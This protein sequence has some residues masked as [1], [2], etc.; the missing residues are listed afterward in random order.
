MNKPKVFLT[1]KLPLEVME[2]LKQE[3]VLEMNLEDRV[4]SKREIVE[5]VKGKDALLCL[6]TDEIDK[7]VLSANP[8]LKIVA[9]YAVGYNNIDIQVATSMGIPVSNTPGVLTETSMPRPRNGE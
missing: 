6:L 9:N 2:R 5:G 7:E 1:R 4:L 3:T 8:D